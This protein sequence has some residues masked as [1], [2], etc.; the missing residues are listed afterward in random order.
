M[1]TYAWIRATAIS[2]VVSRAKT[3]KMM[4]VAGRLI[5]DKAIVAAPIRCISR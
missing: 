2:R 4:G 5:V 1:K 3:V